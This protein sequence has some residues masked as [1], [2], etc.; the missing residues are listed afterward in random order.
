[1]LYGA[2]ELMSGTPVVWERVLP[3]FG[4]LF[5]F[6]VW[7]GVVFITEKFPF[8]RLL[9]ASLFAGL[10]YL[11]AQVLTNPTMVQAAMVT[12]AFA[13]IGYFGEVWVK[14]V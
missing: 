12:A 4:I 6:G 14:H 7:A 11:L 2:L 8:R 5:L 9:H 10:G 13:F 1:M 3:M